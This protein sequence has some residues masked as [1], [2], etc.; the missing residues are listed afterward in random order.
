MAADCKKRPLFVRYQTDNGQKYIFDAATGRIIRVSDVLDA[1]VDDYGLYST[2]DIVRKHSKFERS[3]IISALNG[4]ETLRRDHFLLGDHFPTSMRRL[5]GIVCGGKYYPLKEFLTTFCEMVILCVTERCNLR[6]DY[7]CYSGRHPNHRTHKNRS[8][9]WET[10]IK[11]VDQILHSRQILTNRCAVTFYG[12]EPL[13]EFELIRQVVRYT[14]AEAEKIGK[15]TAF[16]L[17]TNGT[18]LD[19]EKVDFLVENNFLVMISLDGP[20]E[21]HDRYRVFAG[22]REGSF[23]V[24]IRNVERF[25]ERYPDYPT[26]GFSMTIAPP[27]LWEETNTFLKRYIDR[28]PMTGVSMVQ[29]ER[30]DTEAILLRG[31]PGT[32]TCEDNVFSDGYRHFSESDMGRLDYLKDNYIRLVCRVGFKEAKRQMPLIAMIIEPLL[33]KIHKRNVTDRHG[34]GVL[35]VTCLPGYSRRF[36]DVDGNYHICERVNESQKYIVGNVDKGIDSV[37]ATELIYARSGMRECANCLALKN[38]NLCFAGFD[39]EVTPVSLCQSSRNSMASILKDYTTLMNCN[40]SIFED[41]TSN[42]LQKEN[43]LRYIPESVI[44]RLLNIAP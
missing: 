4:I 39:N 30:D 43:K 33:I 16:S 38:C 36:C 28:F 12:G 31:C 3:Q 14:K 22:S 9:T 17:T 6:C 19:D 40:T 2:D 29:S 42:E 23:E 18:L 24:A 20:Q 10:A 15:K 34:N 11:A 37:R 35:L 7:C 21:A 32:D 1:I 27:I 5:A 25:A 41:V 44:D 26:R 8:M 13:L